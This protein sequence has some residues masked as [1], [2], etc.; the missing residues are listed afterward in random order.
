MCSPAGEVEAVYEL[1]Y[2]TV[3]IAVTHASLPK[4]AGG[5]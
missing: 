3:E 5:G 4:F 1:D 2:L